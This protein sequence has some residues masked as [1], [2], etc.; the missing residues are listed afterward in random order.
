MVFDWDE[1]YSVGSAVIDTEHKHLFELG[2][3]AFS[4]ADNEEKIHKIRK[5]IPELYT[6]M[7]KHFENEEQYML[8]IN[9]PYLE[10]HKQHHKSIIHSMN[11]F[12][13]TVPTLSASTIEHELASSVK[14]WIL[15][16]IENEDKQIG[17][18]LQNQKRE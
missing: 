4:F 11:K 16:H 7:K 9:Y 12:L 5:I 17:D 15:H 13:K 14:Y 1:K 6:C 3:A 8:K 2:E 18:W 10:E